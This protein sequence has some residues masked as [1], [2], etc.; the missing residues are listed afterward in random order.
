MVSV[1]VRV[2]GLVHLAVQV[3]LFFIV[4]II[5]FLNNCLDNQPV[6]TD[7]NATNPDIVITPVASQAQFAISI[8]AIEE[9]DVRGEQIRKIT[10]NNLKFTRNDQSSGVNQKFVYN[11]TLENGASLAITISFSFVFF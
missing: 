4:I 2:I 8:K 1:F 11:S 6:N 9:R 7:I 5:Y 3:L 10:I